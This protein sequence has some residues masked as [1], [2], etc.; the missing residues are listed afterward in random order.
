MAKYRVLNKEEL[1]DLEKEFI[2]FLVLNGIPSDEWLSIRKDHEKA[3]KMIELFSDV[4]FEKILR[5]VKYVDHY[6]KNSIKLFKCDSERIYLRGIDTE[7]DTIDFV[8]A[9]N[10]QT[11][12]EK[13]K[14]DV[15]VYSSDKAYHPIREEEIFKMLQ[16]GCQISTGTFYNS[17]D[18]LFPRKKK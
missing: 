10:V 14:A 3:D 9:E 13:H 8:N 16:S 2:D 1:Q 4:V 12:L 18:P 11:I 7:E 15:Q 17:L 5:E 6:A